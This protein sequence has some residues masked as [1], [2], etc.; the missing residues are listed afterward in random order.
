MSVSSAPQ[1][2][3]THRLSPADAPPPAPAP[4][5]LWFDRALR[6]MFFRRLEKLAAGR[7]VIRD[8][9]SQQVF[10]RNS[11][12]L[13]DHCVVPGEGR[14]EGGENS[15]RRWRRPWKS[16]ARGSI[17]RWSSAGA[18]AW[19]RP[20]SAAIGT[21]TIS[22]RLP[23]FLPQ[24]GRPVRP[25]IGR[26]ETACAMAPAG[27][28]L[29]RNTPRGQPPEHRRPLR[30]GRRFLLPLPRRDDGL[31][32]ARVP[33]PGKHAARGLAGEIRADL[34]Q[35]GASAG[36]SPAGSRRRLGRT[37]RLCRRAF[38]LPRNDDHHLP[39][40]IRLH[41]AAYRAAGT[42]RSRP[43]ALRRLPPRAGNLRQAGLRGNDRARGL[44]VL[45]RL[46]PHVLQA[47]EARRADALADDH[48][49]D[50][51]FEEYRR[52]V[53]FIRR[54]IF[55]GGCLPSLGAICR[56][57]GR[58]SDL[59]IIHLEDLTRHTPDAGGLRRKFRENEAAV[60]ALGFD[61]HLPHL[62]LL[63]LLLRSRLP[64]TH[65]RRRADPAHQNRQ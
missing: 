46:L 32:L 40:P 34:P 43:C 20:T 39:A 12:P 55:P 23:A 29:R 26:G 15:S 18:W 45:R 35:I 4:Q 53:D 41:P 9:G 51:Y 38:R 14:G 44:R 22:S 5:G 64:R 61:R 11:L 16:T 2:P 48:H 56:A 19:R 24:S 36:G 57:V 62:G 1:A 8:S 49:A 52:G 63:L 7:L 33:P 42:G 60:R 59:Q 54:Y 10:G 47:L 6:G 28:R 31:L 25:G 3:S 50:Q 30:S 58:A 65:H 27:H 17:G 21:A 37:G 13:P